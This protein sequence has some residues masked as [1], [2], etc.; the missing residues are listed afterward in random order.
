MYLVNDLENFIDEESLIAEID[1]IRKADE[2]GKHNT[3][4][5]YNCIVCCSYEISLSY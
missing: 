5:L 4:H 1:R 3:K 2:Q